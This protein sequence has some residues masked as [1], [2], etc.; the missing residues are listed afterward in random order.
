[1]VVLT[2]LMTP[3][4][5]SDLYTTAIPSTA[6]ITVDGESVTISAYNINGFNYFKLRDIAQALK[7]TQK[8][9]G[10]GLNGTRINL[11]TNEA[12]TPQEN[13]ENNDV[14][15]TATAYINNTYVFCVDH[16]PIFLNAYIINNFNYIKLRDLANALN[17]NIRWISDT[18]TVEISTEVTSEYKTVTIFVETPKLEIHDL[19]EKSWVVAEGK[20]TGKSDAFQI[21]STGGIVNNFT[22]YYF[23]IST[24]HRG[25]TQKNTVTVR[26]EGGTVGKYQ[27]IWEGVSQIEVGNSYLLFLYNPGHGGFFNTAGDYYYIL[28]NTQGIFTKDGDTYTSQA[29]ATISDDEFHRQ[30][31]ALRDAP[32]DYNYFRN[33]YM[34]NCNHKLKTGAI[35]QE[36]YDEAILQMD[37]YATII[38]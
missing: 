8:E 37:V 1:M 34:E 36:E 6:V 23:E 15:R 2:L 18:N 14:L 29:Y 13:T 3:S 22:D 19:L 31:D 12:Y 33:Q 4:L 28:G 11:L 35:T 26:T 20:F 16:Q 24:I 17:F 9:F 30:L 5:A 25:I 7:G 21:K 27:E 32:V 10:I 38:K